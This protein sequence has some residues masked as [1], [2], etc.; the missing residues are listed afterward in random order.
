LPTVIEEEEEK[1]KGTTDLDAN[2]FDF[3]L[4]SK[5]DSIESVP[6]SDSESH[7]SS[8]DSSA[9]SYS[10]SSSSS[11]DS[12]SSSLSSPTVSSSSRSFFSSSS[13]SSS[14]NDGEEEESKIDA[15]SKKR[16]RSSFDRQDKKESF[17]TKNH[18]KKK[19][20]SDVPLPT[21]HAVRSTQ[22]KV[23][24]TTS[25]E[26]TRRK[27]PITKEEWGNYA[28]GGVYKLCLIC[29]LRG[30]KRPY[31]PN[32]CFKH[33]VETG[34]PEIGLC[35]ESTTVKKTK[36]SDT[37]TVAPWEMR[38]ILQSV[39]YKLPG[40]TLNALDTAKSNKRALFRYLQNVTKGLR[41]FDPLDATYMGHL[42]SENI[43]MK[44]RIERIRDERK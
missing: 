6:N 8:F 7:D 15:S 10:Y 5:K 22:Q 29:D 37:P 36:P 40:I 30:E 13:S 39:A 12:S 19:A 20:R 41:K 14:S 23:S 16:K 42:N 38:R 17:L 35:V 9:C 4:S 25:S 33:H 43:F 24:K 2:V 26:A 1:E 44:K 3:I 27:G 11:H 34:H 28:Y 18:P 21:T 32:A 31:I